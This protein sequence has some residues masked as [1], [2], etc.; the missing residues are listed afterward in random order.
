MVTRDEERNRGGR[1]SAKVLAVDL[2]GSHATCAVVEHEGVVSEETVTLAGDQRLG[3]A[4]PLLVGALRRAADG[5][6]VDTADC[7]GLGFG[8]CGVVDS[9]AAKV[10]ATNAK[11]DD[12]PG[13]DLVSWCEAE[14]GVPLHLEN[15]ARLALLGERHAG[16]A[17]DC[18]DVVM[19]TLGTGIGGVA[20]IGGQFLR[21]RHHQAGLLGG[22]LTVAFDGRPCT[23]GSRGCMEAEASTWA[24]PEICR[25]WAGFAESGLAAASELNFETLF[26]GARAGDGVSIEVRDHCL[27]VWGAGAVSM[28]HAWD[29][30][31]LVI[32]GGVMRDPEQVLPHVRAHVARHAWTPWGQVEVRAA[33]LGNRAALL[34]AVPLVA[35]TGT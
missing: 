33:A 3:D 21:G 18:D 16:A 25:G 24:L 6:G 28:I 23:C 20:M 5:A 10:V 13:L 26:A 31:V 7:L 9:V 30:E 1:G 27:G 4:L 29:P 35:A 11:Y 14:L 2:G 32:G 34:G 17:R 22:H 19:I 12:A 15:D 8:F